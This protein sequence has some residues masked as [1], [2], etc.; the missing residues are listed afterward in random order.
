MARSDVIN[1]IVAGT[2]NQSR[3]RGL[4]SSRDGQ[5][6]QEQLQLYPTCKLLQIK[7]FAAGEPEDEKMRGD[8][9][10]RDA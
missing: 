1:V 2:L 3:E 7:I 9:V 6:G 5:P 4:S 10:T 8:E